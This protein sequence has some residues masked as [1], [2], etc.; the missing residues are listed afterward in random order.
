MKLPKSPKY[1]EDKDVYL[2]PSN[3]TSSFQNGL[4][5]MSCRPY[6]PHRNPQTQAIAK[7]IGCFL[8]IDSKVLLLDNPFINH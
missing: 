3:E 5:L 7:V 6:G 4:Q 1:G 2:L 8:Q